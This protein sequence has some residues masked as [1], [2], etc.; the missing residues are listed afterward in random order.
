[1]LIKFAISNLTALI[2]GG[3]ALRS[4]LKIICRY[5]LHSLPNKK[6]SGAKDHGKNYIK[7]RPPLVRHLL[8]NRLLK[9]YSLWKECAACLQ[10]L[11]VPS[12]AVSIDN[13]AKDGGPEAVRHLCSFT[14]NL[15]GRN[16]CVW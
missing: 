16:F 13:Y 9:H 12:N 5:E 10:P 14:K 15:C 7:V 4:Y 11:T 8:R 6:V 3:H 2:L 1:M